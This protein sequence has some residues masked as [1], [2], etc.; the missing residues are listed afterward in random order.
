MQALAARLTRLLRQAAADPDRRIS[1]LD[2]LTIVERRRLLL[3]WN[4]TARPVPETTVPEL[5][6][7]QAART[8]DAPAVLSA[9]AEL[10]YGELNARANQLARYLITLGAG[11]E[12]LVAIAMPRS[13]EMIVALLAVLKS[14]AAYVPVDPGYPPGRRPSCSPTPRR[15]SRSPRAPW[16]DPCQRRRPRSSWMTPR[17]RR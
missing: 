9:A 16:P 14:G 11:P 5:F 13:A 1:Q 6:E 12:R 15:R 10:T 8:P 2:L 17:L 7:Q 4:D 3:D